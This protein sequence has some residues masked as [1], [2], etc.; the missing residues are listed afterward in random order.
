[1][2]D[3]GVLSKKNIEGLISQGYQYI[4]G[5]RI[6][7]ESSKMKSKILSTPLDNG[8]AITIKKEGKQRLIVTYSS[9][10]AS[11][12][13]HNRARGLARL[14]KALIG[15]KLTKANLNNR[16]YNKYLRMKGS[17]EIELD[18]EKLEQDMR[19]DGLKG[20]QTNSHLNCDQIVESYNSLWQIE[21]AFRISKTDLRIRPI[22]HRIRNRIEAHI[23]LSFTAYSIYKEFER[24]MTKEKSKIS[25]KE[26]AE[27][28][29]NMYQIIVSMPK[30]R[31]SKHILLG[32]DEKQ[33]EIKNIV[34]KYY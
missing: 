5:G 3:S 24:I 15:G 25:L 32:M 10:R 11:K 17:M 19:W 7:S 26:A 13:K 4:I 23:C 14:E 30:S 29:K 16:G 1:V 22:Y 21:E 8:Q 20:Y 6:K 2:A 9:K 34:E 28:T 27:L 33:A 18:E 12:D 31:H